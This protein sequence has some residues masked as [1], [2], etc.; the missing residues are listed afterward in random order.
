[1]NKTNTMNTAQIGNIVYTPSKFTGKLI[2]I[3]NNGA[4][5]LMGVVQLA[6]GGTATYRLRHL[7]K[8]PR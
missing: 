6:T 7:R 2:D 4:G 1:M 8:V 5:V 3:Y